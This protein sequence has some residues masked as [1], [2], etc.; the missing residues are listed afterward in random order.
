MSVTLNLTPEIQAGLLAK[1][2]A[3]GL[4]LD[5]FVSRQL[6]ALTQVSAPASLC[7]PA[8]EGADHITAEQWENELDSWVNSF[9]Q[10]PVLSDD[11]LRR[12]NWY[13]D[14]W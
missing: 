9:P 12:E 14:R 8:G 6:E 7:E 11:A 1:A 5:Q 2:Q 10:K 13:P 4:S 3:A